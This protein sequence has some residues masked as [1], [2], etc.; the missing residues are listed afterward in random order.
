MTTAATL[1]A[2]RAARG[3][4]MPDCYIANARPGQEVLVAVH[5]ISRN[6]AEI[7]MR[8]AA[9]P[10]FAQTT[11]IAPLFDKDRFGQYQQLE[12]RRPGQTGADAGLI[13]LLDDLA[14]V[15]GLLTTR[16]RLFGF[17]GGAQMAHR[18]AMFHPARVA[19]LCVVSAGWYA[20]PDSTIVW[21]YGIGDGMGASVVGPDFLDI[22]TTVI[23]GNRDTRVDASVRQDPEILEHQGRNRLRR[24]RCYVRALAAYA[25]ACRKPA[26]PKLLTLHGVSHDFSQCVT[27]GD[28]ITV[29]ADSLLDKNVSSNGPLRAHQ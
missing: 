5:G 21:P 27:E 29:A 28:L 13:A 24:A 4:G 18:F 8:F 14:S 22:P 25:E 19:R 12:V 23:V 7:A 3:A 2:F 15:E 17:S 6:A 26:R 10:A 1:P 11:I 16:V 20:M 9:H